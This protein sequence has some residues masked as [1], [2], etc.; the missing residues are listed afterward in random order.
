MRD[1]LRWGG[2]ELADPLAD[3]DADPPL[4]RSGRLAAASRWLRSS[5]RPWM[6][7]PLVAGMVGLA[8]VVPAPADLEWPGQLVAASEQLEVRAPADRHPRATGDYLA[9]RRRTSSVL[10]WL[11]SAAP[12]G[13]RPV[14]RAPSRVDDLDPVERALL[15]GAG[16]ARGRANA[17]QL[18]YTAT[19]LDNDLPAAALALALWTFDAAS[20]VDLSRGRRVLALGALAADG[21]LRCPD[22]PVEAAVEASAPDL[23]LVAS[24]CTTV[25]PVDGSPVVEVESLEAAVVALNRE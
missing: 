25:A 13:A 2:A 12:G 23:V 5:W 1:W 8:A 22:S 7:W 19:T 16:V 11:A 21:T 4:T 6:T 20:E 14:A 15:M 17:T 18:G 3:P 9:P 24:G 10:A